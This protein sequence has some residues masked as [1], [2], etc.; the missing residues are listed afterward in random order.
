MVGDTMDNR[1]LTDTREASPRSDLLLIHH[2]T[3]GIGKINEK[4]VETTR[5]TFNDLLRTSVARLEQSFVAHSD[6]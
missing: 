4:N 1:A 3:A 5:L 2:M 6:G